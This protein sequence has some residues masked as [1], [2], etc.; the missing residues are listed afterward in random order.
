[1]KRADIDVANRA[2]HFGAG[3]TWA[4]LDAATQQHG[5][6]VTG[7]RV[8]HTGIG[9]PDPGQRLGWLER[10]YGM[11]CASLLSAEVVTAAGGCCGPAQAKTLICCGD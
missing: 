3:L 4:E 10:K 11:T 1:M 5:L 8:S 7:G 9:R 2:G 6:A